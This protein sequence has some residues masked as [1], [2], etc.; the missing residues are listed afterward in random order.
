MTV[1]AST[2][3]TSNIIGIATAIFSG[4]PDALVWMWISAYFGLTSKFSKCML[5]IKYRE[6]NK[7]V[8]SLRNFFSIPQAYYYFLSNKICRYFFFFLWQTIFFFAKSNTLY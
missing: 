1:L 2:I 6:V 8:I 4:G 7:N 3:G 5:A